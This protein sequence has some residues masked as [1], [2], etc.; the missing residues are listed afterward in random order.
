[1]PII[2]CALRLKF[3]CTLNGDPKK[4]TY[5]YRQHFRIPKARGVLWT[6]MQGV[7]HFRISIRQ[8]VNNM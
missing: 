1:M 6:G 2:N 5:L 7:E 8:G 4:Y 3:T